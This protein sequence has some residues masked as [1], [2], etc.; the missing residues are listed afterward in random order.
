VFV[1]STYGMKARRYETDGAEIVVCPGQLEFLGRNVLYLLGAAFS[2]QVD[3][4]HVFTGASTVV[5]SFTLL[6]GRVMRIPSVI[7]F[8]G[9]EQ[10]EIGGLMQRILLPFALNVATSIGVNTPYTGGFIP[11]P[12][13]RKTHVLFGGAEVSRRL[14]PSA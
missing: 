12:L 2:K 10:F 11:R 9:K 1:S 7:S 8:F 4:I 14:L 3:V 5:G 6:L 13:H